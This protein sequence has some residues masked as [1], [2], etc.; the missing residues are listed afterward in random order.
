MSAPLYIFLDEGG[1]FDFSSKGSRYFTLTSISTKRPFAFSDALDSYKY[2]CIEWGL[3]QE[4]FHCADDNSHLRQRVFGIIAE[5]LSTLLID[6]IIIEK[7]KTGHLLQEPKR[8]YPQMIGYLLRYVIE[9]QNQSQISEVIVITDNIPLN[10]KRKAVEKAIKI[11][12]SEM[13]SDTVKYR[14]IH[15]ASKAHHGL[16]IA[17][18]CNWAIYRKWERDDAHHYDIIKNGIRSE[19]DIF[20][21]GVR[22]YY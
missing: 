21:T 22:R 11:T 2:D 3:N 1:N 19:F 6:S 13:L 5:N 16:Q 17:D 10:E 4:Y 7:P 9:R 8:F 15:H 14:I 18:Y 12:L 20:R